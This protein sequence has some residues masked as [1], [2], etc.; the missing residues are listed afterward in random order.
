[1]PGKSSTA[2]CFNPHQLELFQAVA[3][4]R[5]ISAA[6]RN[7]SYGIGQPAISNQIAAL[8]RQIGRKLFERRP[9]RLTAHGRL[10][11]NHTQ[12]FFARLPA[13]W[14]ELQAEPAEVLH[15]AAD[16]LL[17]EAWLS[18]VLAPV[19]KRFP[20]TR[21]E[22]HNGTPSQL[23]AWQADREVQLI[24][25]TG[26]YRPPGWRSQ[27]LVRPCL[28]LWVRAACP[29]KSAGW[30]WQQARPT[31]CLIGPPPDD[32][33]PA[34]FQRGLRA[35]Q[36][37]WSTRLRADSAAL[38]HAL[39]RQGLGV[40]LGLILPEEV[41]PVGLR[42]LPL[43]HFEPVPISACWRPPLTPA[44]ELFLST[45]RRIASHRWRDKG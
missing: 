34:V 16:S 37:T 22:L 5:G 24:V 35:L 26:H 33:L 14:Q 36:V 31:H 7:L 41:R 15:L 4:Y 27:I 8:E 17:G 21:F 45:L 1:M 10:L 3:R 40:G 39:V 19:A 6:A 2:H 9:F 38:M 11:Q 30:F 18:A 32:P 13:L 12:P 25:T 42:S 44:L 43:E 20:A 29:I 28:G 23:G